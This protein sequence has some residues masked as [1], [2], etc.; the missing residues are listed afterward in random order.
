MEAEALEQDVKKMLA[1]AELYDEISSKAPGSTVGLK[2]KQFKLRLT[3]EEMLEV[4]K[5]INESIRKIRENV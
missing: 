1:I 3:K 5:D 4:I 2:N